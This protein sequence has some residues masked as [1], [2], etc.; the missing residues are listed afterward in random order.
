MRHSTRRPGLA[1]GARLP[2]AID[3]ASISSRLRHWGCANQYEATAGREVS[4][5]GCESSCLV[6]GGQEDLEGVAGQQHQV[7]TPV[8]P[9]R[10]RVIEHPGYACA[11]VAPFRQGEH[12]RGRID[13]D[14]ETIRSPGQR[15]RQHAGAAAEVEYC[16][17]PLRQITAKVE[18][19]GPP[20]LN[21][22]K[23]EPHPD[24]CNGR[25]RSFHRSHPQRGSFVSRAGTPSS[26]NRR[27]HWP[28]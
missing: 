23:T 14:D 21:V 27:Q 1:A 24:R 25:C 12:R 7:E 15:R 13:A 6:A 5:D 9:G 4:R 17:A 2:A 8:Q 16:A 28:K 22:I 26:N 18:I 11:P 10:S 3:R 20:I 19:L